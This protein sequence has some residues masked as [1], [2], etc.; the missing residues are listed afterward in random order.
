MPAAAASNPVPAAAANN[1]QRID[2]MVSV[3]S[4]RPG[5]FPPRTALFS[6]DT[7]CHSIVSAAPARNK[8]VNAPGS[9]V[10]LE[11]P[12]ISRYGAVQLLQ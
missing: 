4:A 5:V 7:R 2:F 1:I 8:W 11:G 10:L 12:G 3:F 9:A 6:D